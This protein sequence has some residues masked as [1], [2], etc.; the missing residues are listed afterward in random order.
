MARQLV[1]LGYRGSG[2]PLK[3]EEFEARKKAAEQFRLSKRMIHNVL[4]SNGKD[5]S[6][7]PFL[8]ALA[9]REEA[10]RSGKMTVPR[11]KRIFYS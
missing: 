8:A 11:Q 5:V 2:E 3:R 6:R 10:N 1:E 7:S 9:E 4:A